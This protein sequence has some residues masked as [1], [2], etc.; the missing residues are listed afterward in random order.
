[1]ESLFGPLAHGRRGDPETS[2]DAAVEITPKIRQL[3]LDVLHYAAGCGAAGFTDPA[4]NAHFNCQTSTY[5][6]RRSELVC[7]GLIEDTGKREGEAKGRKHA[8][9]KI[10]G[11]G[12]ARIG[13]LSLPRA[14]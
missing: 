9:W 13:E 6:T 14:A 4:M 11:A 1:L 7:L 8:V 3:Q 12:L 2:R 10:T 5:R